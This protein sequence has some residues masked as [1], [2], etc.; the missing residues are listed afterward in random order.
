M[1][2]QKVAVPASN[3]FSDESSS[4]MFRLLRLISNNEWTKS[5]S[6]IK[7]NFLITVMHISCMKEFPFGVDSYPDIPER[8]ESMVARCVIHLVL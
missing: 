1:L 4:S 2:M 7:G 3:P 8:F 6:N 5:F